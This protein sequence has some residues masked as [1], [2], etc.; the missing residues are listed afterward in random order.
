MTASLDAEG[1]T[2]RAT[3]GATLPIAATLPN[4]RPVAVI[5]AL[6]GFN[7]YS[8]AFREPAIDW[9]AKGIATYAPDQRGFGRA[10]HRGLWAGAETM[11][12]DAADLL[13]ALRR[14]HPGT[15]LFLLGESMGGAV[16]LETMARFRPAVDGVVL[17]A[18][19]TWGGPALNPFYNFSLWFAAHTTPWATFTGRGLKRQASDNIEM[20]KALGRDPLVIKETR[21]DTIYGLV[22]LMGRA[23]E[24]AP[25][26][27][28]PAL[29]LYGRN[30]EIIPP[31]A[32]EALLA[33]LP[34]RPSAERRVAIYDTGWHMLLRDLGAA[35]VRDDVG[36][37]VLGRASSPAPERDPALGRS[38]SDAAARRGP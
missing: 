31:G 15:P 10:P 2:F 29:I 3:D 37:F 24:A 16:A 9:A 1:K 22:G 12:R 33:R 13:T 21:V 23:L 34:E 17:L 27:D 14:R 8:N 19:A 5:A 32:F 38:E 4:G 7:D 18:P 26:F 6:H 11:A 35:R 30:D 25:D 28:A 36:A 20:L